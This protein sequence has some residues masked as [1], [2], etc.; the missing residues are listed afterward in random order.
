MNPQV[1]IEYGY[2][3]HIFNKGINGSNIFYNDDNYLHFIR[4]YEKHIEPISETY[5]WV[6][7]KNHFHL[8]IRIKEQNEIMDKY[9]NNSYSNNKMLY[10]YFSDFFNAYTQAIN[11][12]I[13]RTGSLFQHPFKRK[14]IKSESYFRNLVIYIHQNPQR[15]KFTDNFR[16]YKWSSYNTILSD[17]PTRMNRDLVIEW[18]ENRENFIF[19]HNVD[20]DSSDS[21]I[22]IE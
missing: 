7:L 11:K 1:P 21:E 2:Y 14:L 20:I 5:A 6:L 22:Y 3:Y 18:F 12:S 15:H 10:S 4:L 17:K 16:N 8:L 13:G 9:P 19:S